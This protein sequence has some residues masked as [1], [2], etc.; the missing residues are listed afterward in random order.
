V[1]NAHATKKG[2][3]ELK[4]GGSQGRVTV[5]A[6]KK[7]SNGNRGALDWREVFAIKGGGPKGGGGGGKGKGQ[8][9]GCPRV[10]PKKTQSDPKETEKGGKE[11]VNNAMS[12]GGGGPRCEKRTTQAGLPG[13]PRKKGLSCYRTSKSLPRQ[14]GKVTSSEKKS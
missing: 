5:R 2:R 9:E 3:A 13:M 10:G 7:R 6:K 12:S 1:G 14:G 4:V 11:N 8:S